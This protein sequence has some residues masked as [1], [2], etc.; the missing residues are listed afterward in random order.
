MFRYMAFVWDPASPAQSDIVQS[1]T[2]KLHAGATEWQPALAV[3]GLTVFYA[4]SRATS[5]VFHPLRDDTG[6]VLG[7]V[8]ER[9]DSDDAP[10]RRFE[11]DQ[12]TSTTIAQSEGR[13]LI[14][15]YWGNYV[16]FIRD[17]RAGK[18]WVVRAPMSHLP[19][20]KVVYQGVVI[21]FSLLA[22]VAALNALPLT[23]NWDYVTLCLASLGSMGHTGLSGVY[24]LRYGECNEVHGP[25]VRQHYYWNP[26]RVAGADRI[27]DAEVAAASLRRVTRQCVRAWAGRHESIVMQISGGLDSS[28]VLACLADMPHRPA[29][30]CMTF[31]SSGPSEDERMYARASAERAGCELIEWPRNSQMRY[32]DALRAPIAETVPAYH[33]ALESF[34]ANQRIA[35]DHGASAI[36]TGGGGDQV[37][38]NA[39]P[40]RSVIDYVY[41][42]GIDSGLFRTA[43]EAGYL[44]QSAVYP[45]LGRALYRGLLFPRR[46]N[47]IHESL[48]HH[49]LLAKR[50]IDAARI[51]PASD[52]PADHYVPEGKQSHIHSILLPWGFYNCLD[53][54]VPLS[55]LAPL[56]SQPLIE[57]CLRIPTYVLT[58][59]GWDRGLARRAFA[60]D[61]PDIILKR[62][63]K[64]RVSQYI[65]GIVWNNRRFVRELLCEGIL[66]QRG[67]LDPTRVSQALADHPTN[68][69]KSNRELTS[70]MCLEI[71][72]RKVC[73]L[74]QQRAAA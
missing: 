67:L 23:V 71:W 33:R 4:S 39:S 43:W 73:A 13:H 72:L 47:A 34:E 12:S 57:L 25:H 42:H 40:H 32:E 51:M 70:T 19:C 6:V 46:W 11:F 14:D 60:A 22:D 63:V 7:D 26:Y 31:Y 36:C 69:I 55:Y 21:Y 27:E 3:T 2:R 53:P 48:R 56:F 16:A 5:L 62:R 18:T 24:A 50:T 52:Y 29:L 30:T 10:P 35:T 1:L 28:I 64:G 44:E 61:L 66:T 49:H 59:G 58:A 38:F 65:S 68:V 45:I 17:A 41:H 15:A 20:L 37:F 9:L 54:L 74:E 8:F